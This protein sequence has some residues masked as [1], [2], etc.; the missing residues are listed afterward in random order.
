MGMISLK[1]QL[2]YKNGFQLSYSEFGDE[3]GYPLL[4]QHGLIASI[5]DY[6]LFDRLIQQKAR[7]ICIARP[8]YG[9]SSPYLLESYAEWA[10][11]VSLLIQEMQLPLFDILGISSGAPYSYA[12]G[13]ELP[14]KVGNIFI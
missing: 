2:S 11:I 4:V 13:A 8:G 12:I 9:E 6:A 5:D 14:E 3:N 1:Q 10:E 7:L